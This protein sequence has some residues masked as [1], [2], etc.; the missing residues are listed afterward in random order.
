SPGY[1]PQIF[2]R[3]P[4]PQEWKDLSSDRRAPLTNKAIAGRYSPGSTF[5][6]C[7]ALA[8]LEH[9]VIAPEQTV[10]CVGQTRLGSRVWYCWKKGGHGTMDMVNAIAQSCDCYFYEVAR[11]LGVD[12]IAAM[13]QKLGLGVL[14]GIGL[15]G[16]QKGLVPTEAWKKAARGEPWQQGETLN[17]G[18]GQG[19]VNVTPIQLLTYVARVANG[20]LAV[21][22]TL[23][24]ATANTVA[25]AAAVARDN[26]DNAPQAMTK[27]ES[28][29][30][31]A[32][33]LDV[34]HRGM[35]G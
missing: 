23:I 27:L 20:G 30:I 4:T 35:Y 9:G 8:G 15:P 34:V 12:R 13:A 18:I 26:T 5:K 10:H 33:H 31:S 6:V 14:T 21:K 16:E 7:V 29:G 11:R 1:D 2:S 25:A 17:V 22:P 3:A 28:L 19:Q 24:R 32:Q